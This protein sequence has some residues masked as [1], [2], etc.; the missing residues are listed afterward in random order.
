MTDPNQFF[1]FSGDMTTL[2]MTVTNPYS[3][4]SYYLDDEYNVNNSVYEGGSGFDYIS[5][6]SAGDFLNIT[7]EFGVQ[8]VKNIEYFNAG[9]G[10]DFISVA[11]ADISYGD[12]I[13]RGAA[14]DD[15]LWGNDGNDDISGAAGND[16]IDGGGGNDELSGNQDND[17][18]FGGIGDDIISGGDGNDFLYGGSDLGLRDLDKDFLDNVSFPDL[19]SNVNI[20]DLMP[21]G[22]S[23]LGV[24]GDNLSVDYRATADISFIKGQAGYNST[25]AIYE[26]MDNG[27]IGNIDILWG[28]V[29]DAGYGV[30]HT[31]DIPTGEDGGAFGFFIIANG[32]KLND[33]YDGL[34]ITGDGNVSI[35]YDYGGANERAGSVHD[36]GNM[37][38]TVYNDG[39]V[40]MVL[41]GATY[42]TTPR[43]GDNS[44][45]PD[46]QTHVVSGQA[47]NG[48]ADVLRIGFEDLVNLGDAD[49]E[50]VLFDFD[51]NEIRVDASEPGNDTLDGGAGDDYL[52]GEAGDDLLIVGEGLDQIYGGSGSDTIQF[53]VADEFIDVIHGFETGVGADVIDLSAVLEFGDDVTDAITDFVQLVQNGS[54]TEIQINAAGDGSGFASLAIIE[55][56]VADS[57]VDLV[58]NGNLIA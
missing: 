38:S 7:N 13:I 54:D 44:L 53:T 45:N 1:S 33:N 51:V 32:H 46:H 24:S 6:S 37:L 40:E 47:N 39:V 20:V 34:D 19:Q 25:L 12:V 22:T 29:K 49:F 9:A 52:Y 3:S 15:I 23:S 26:V 30:T 10:G 55:G 17:Q 4:K 18:I 35:I 57:L 36:D 42:H 43:D 21:P 8:V 5:M 2:S 27:A 56:G 41:E 31:I 50:D 11:H 28:N 58:N 48:D 14:G 16:I